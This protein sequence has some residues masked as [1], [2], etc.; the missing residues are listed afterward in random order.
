MPIA[1]GAAPSRPAGARPP[2]VC[3]PPT[4]K[5]SPPEPGSSPPTG[6]VGAFAVG[7][8]TVE[9]PDRAETPPLTPTPV[10]VAVSTTWPA[11]T[12]ASL[13]VYVWSAVHVSESPGASPGATGVGQVTEPRAGSSTA[14]VVR[15]TLPMFVTR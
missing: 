10:A 13:T 11:S 1:T 4:G 8:V 5:P 7:T 15:S 9:G 12:S 2:P 6:T 3:T 14:T